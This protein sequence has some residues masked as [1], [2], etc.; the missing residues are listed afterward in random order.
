MLFRKPLRTI[1]WRVPTVIIL[2]FVAGL[3]FALGHHAFYDHLDGQ[4]VDGRLFDQQINLAVGQAFAFLVR[5]SLVISVGTSYW[6]VFWGTMLHGTL[7]ISQ[8]DALAGMLGS[9]LDLLN[10][11]ASSTRPMLLALALLSWMVPLASILPP[12]TLSVQSTTITTPANPIVGIDVPRFDGMSMA[13]L[14]TNSQAPA[15]MMD[16]T[17]VGDSVSMTQYQRP[18]RQLSRLV[19]ATAYRGAIPNHHASFSNSTYTLSFPAPALRCEVVPQDLLRYFNDAM[20]CSL[21]LDQSED[22]P[23]AEC[24]NLITYLSWVPGKVLGNE[25][26]TSAEYSIPFMPN[27]LIDGTLPLGFRKS[28]YQY[29]PRFIGGLT[30]GAAS[31]YIATR[32]QRLPYDINNWDLLNC[33]MYNASYTV[34]V[35]S[36]SNSRGI[37]SKPEIRTLNSVPFDIYASMRVMNTPLLANESA[38]FGYL[39]LMESFN[40]LIVGTIFGTKY[41]RVRN[42]SYYIEES[43]TVQNE[44]YKQTLLPFATELLPFLG[45]PYDVSLELEPNYVPLD[46]KQWTAVETID[47]NLT[48][49]YPNEA[50]SASTFN[51]SLA[52]VLEELFQNMTLS[53]FSSPFFV[54]Q[55]DV[56]T[57]VSRNITQNTYAYDS[58]NLFISYGLAVGFALV[59]GVAGCISIYYNGASYSNRF[60]TV[61]RTTRGQEL[62]DLVVHND[63]TGVDPLP[64]QLA[65]TRIDLRRGQLESEREDDAW[66]PDTNSEQTAMIGVSQSGGQANASS[67]EEFEPID[68]VLTSIHRFHTL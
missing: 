65:K 24:E 1:H 16:G 12:A 58:R 67:E 22:D 17:T 18:T 35:T 6:Q 32:S 38:A 20:N 13:I 49:S 47:G 14:P 63:R 54:E 3:A 56:Y 37:L 36:D 66:R 27:S 5:A 52:L 42:T 41:S 34:N 51:R 29:D 26:S 44:A 2:A 60:S 10:L 39:A 45:V 64:K 68:Q 61:L 53:M 59:A 57:D 23:K 31:V 25:S 46:P 50:F 21:L 11:K 8:I 15:V 55:L 7:A 30:G 43:L 28:S 4:S 48:V 9:I 33:S 62:D 19:T 40:R